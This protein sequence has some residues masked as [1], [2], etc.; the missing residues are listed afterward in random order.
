MKNRKD[1]AHY[2]VCEH[3]AYKSNQ[4]YYPYYTYFEYFKDK[5][6]F[7]NIPFNI[8]DI[9]YVIPSID[10]IK[11]IGKEIIEC[12]INNIIFNQD[13]KIIGYSCEER[14]GGYFYYS[15]IFYLIL[16]EKTVFFTREEA[17][18]SLKNRG[19]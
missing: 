7:I 9:V 18:E 14:Y 3:W 15:C 10:G 5:S 2:D 13:G 1:C 11:P 17:K 19:K 16:L 8:G 4:E 6:K 12:E